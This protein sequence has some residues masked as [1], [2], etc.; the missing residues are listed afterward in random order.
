[1]QSKKENDLIFIRL[2]LGEYMYSE[3]EQACQKHEVVLRL[4]CHAWPV[5]AI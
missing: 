3:L 4:S 1:M 5:K 2:F